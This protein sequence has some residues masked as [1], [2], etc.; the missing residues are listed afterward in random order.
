MP[1]FAKGK[2]GNP[3]G[4]PKEDPELKE[5]ARTHTVEAVERLVYWMRSSE[6]KA[7][8]TASLSILERGHGKAPQEMQ[9]SGGIIIEILESKPKEKSKK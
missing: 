6:P 5:L 2:S 7:S 3:S 4:R 9:H 8:V 1:K